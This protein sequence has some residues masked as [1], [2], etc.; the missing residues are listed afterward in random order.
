MP[1]I[2]YLSGIQPGM[3]IDLSRSKQPV[4]MEWYRPELKRRLESMSRSVNEEY[5]QEFLLPDGRII[6]Q[7]AEA[8][9]DEATALKYEDNWAKDSGLSLEAWRQNKEKGDG[10]TAEMAIT[11][12]LNKVIGKDFIVARACDY[13]DYMHGIDS[14]IIDKKTG[15]VICGFDEVVD[16]YSYGQDKKKDKMKKLAAG[17]GAQIKY[18]ATIQNG[19]LVRASFTNVP[20]F[21]VSLSKLDLSR[22]M[23]SIRNKPENET[24]EEEGKIFS[25]MIISLREQSLKLE[26][27]RHLRDE[28]EAAI[29]NLEQAF[30]AANTQD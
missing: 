17:G 15:K 18:G 30:A 9:Q 4:N 8:E 10:T 13:D 27:N 2:E 23:E 19:E 7:G 11:V 3:K 22:L 6:A 20:S 26:N 24:G 12:V 5:G 14:V 21:F 29:A 28:A 25:K 16:D 1:S